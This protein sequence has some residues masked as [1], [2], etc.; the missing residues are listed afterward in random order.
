MVHVPYISKAL[1][2]FLIYIYKQS[3]NDLKI[4]NDLQ[5][6]LFSFAMTS[7]IPNVFWTVMYIV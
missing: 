6:Y 5:V 3:V 4:L 7:Q 1:N 2:D